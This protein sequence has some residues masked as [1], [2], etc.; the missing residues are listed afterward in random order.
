L[1]PL[2]L[3]VVRLEGL[4]HVDER[5]DHVIGL[6]GEGHDIYGEA[7]GEQNQRGPVPPLCDFAFFAPNIK[8]WPQVPGSAFKLQRD[9]LSMIAG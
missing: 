4:D 2:F 3:D 6:D 1:T 8:L 7:D 9:P 5:I